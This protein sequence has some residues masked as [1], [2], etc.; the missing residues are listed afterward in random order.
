MAPTF[1][2]TSL[3]LVPFFLPAFLLISANEAR[4]THRRY[5]QAVYLTK[6]WAKRVVPFALA[7][8]FIPWVLIGYLVC[9]LLD[10][11]RNTQNN[12]STLV[13]YFAGNG[14]FTWLL[15]PFNLL[16]DLITLPY[17]NKGTYRLED[18]P[19]GYQKE[20]QFVID[21]VRKRDLLAQL[22]TK[23]G[24]TKRAMIFFK[25]YGQ[26]LSSSVRVPEFH[27]QYSYIRT[28]GVSTFNA[29]QSTGLHFGPL[30]LTLRVLYNLKVTEDPGVYIQVGR[31]THHWRDNNLFIFDDTL[32]HL[33]CNNSDSI[34]YCLF[35]D[36]L[37]P[38]AIFWVLSALVSCVRFLMFPLRHIFYRNWS[39]MQ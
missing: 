29:R 4:P 3:R 33:S 34:R 15:S 21:T 38:C 35:V 11:S 16:I 19:E 36:I 5:A 7:G 39:V 23:V 24:D 9:G 32:Q 30:R 22:A 20:I 25:W 6:K 37:R 8:Y 26:N 17:W 31:H 27:E 12:L 14:V 10:V 2:I 13:Q 1:L 28:I 18:L